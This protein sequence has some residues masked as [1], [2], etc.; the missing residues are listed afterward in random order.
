MIHTKWHHLLPLIDADE[1]YLTAPPGGV[2]SHTSEWGFDKKVYRDFIDGMSALPK[3]VISPELLSLTKEKNFTKSLFD[4]K[5]AGLMRL[6]FPTMVVEIPLPS[7]KNC[8]YCIVLHDENAG[9]PPPWHESPKKDAI[10]PAEDRPRPKDFFGLNLSIMKDDYGEYLVTSPACIYI[11]F[12]EGTETEEPTLRFEGS[13]V[14][15]L[16]ANSA[17]DV[18]IERVNSLVQ[19]VLMKDGHAVALSIYAALLL[20]ITRGVAR[21]VIDVERLNKKRTLAGKTPIPKHTYIRIGHVYRSAAGEEAD[22]YIPRKSPRPHWRRGH[23]KMVRYG[24]GHSKLKQKFIAPR[25]VAVP[26]DALIEPN[27]PEYTVVD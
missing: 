18:Y 12:D 21:E 6:P 10:E 15:W 1:V 27:M 23:L 13:G 24:P 25:L 16:I 4:L 19:Q 22:E 20:M 2:V 3:F 5:R 17:D 14:S 7:R 9:V 8:H 26:A 11:G